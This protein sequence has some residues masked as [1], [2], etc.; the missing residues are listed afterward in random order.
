VSRDAEL[1][2]VCGL[3]GHERDERGDDEGEAALHDGGKLETEA[4]AGPG[5]HDADDI[6]SGEDVF[7]GLALG[8]TEGVVAE[9]GAKCVVEGK[10]GPKFHCN[11]MRDEVGSG[12]LRLL[13]ASRVPGI[14]WKRTEQLDRAAGEF[15]LR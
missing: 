13:F 14:G 2:E 4:L 12:N 11:A 5:G 3:V 9:D 10:H 1:A 8:G 15:I 7:D 6:V